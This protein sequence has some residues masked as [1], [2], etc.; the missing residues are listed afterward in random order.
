MKSDTN[1]NNL[2][3]IVDDSPEIISMMNE[4]IS[5]ADMTPL[6]ALEGKQ[7]VNIANKMVPDVILLDALMP[8]M[9]GFETCRM[10]KA[11][12][13]LKD[14]P[15]IFMT[16]LKDTESIVKG[17]EVGGTDYLTKPI[18]PAELIARLKVHMSN[19]RTTISTKAALDISGQNIFAVDSQGQLLWSTPQVDKFLSTIENPEDLTQLQQQLAIWL[20]HNP[21][22]GTRF[23]ISLSEHKYTAVYMGESE[24]GESL[25]K[26]IDEESVDEKNVLMESFSVT[27]REAEVL[28]WLARGKANREIAEIL[29]MSPRTVGK[30]IEQI[31]RKL[32]VDNRT[33][34]AMMAVESL[35]KHH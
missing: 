15:V 5:E 10:I 33:A 31:F 9:D 25:V 11:S 34:A 28:L 22:V 1:K 3:L 12:D 19:A 21:A 4:V 7:A 32:E 29:E 2:V 24:S 8:G 35:L 6:V 20:S 14:I 30:H 13:E 27:A 17:F 18:N 16:G 26:F 23:H